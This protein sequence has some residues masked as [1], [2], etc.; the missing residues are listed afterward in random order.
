LRARVPV[1]ECRFPPPSGP[2]RALTL[3]S[4]M[5]LSSRRVAACLA[6]LLVAAAVPYCLYLYRSWQSGNELADVLAE[7]DRTAAPWRLADLQSRQSPIGD[8]LTAAALIKKARL[9][10]P[11][12]FS[13]V[14][15]EFNILPN[16]P[17]T[18]EQY[19]KLRAYLDNVDENVKEAR[20][21]IEL[22]PG[23][24]PVRVSADFFGS[25]VPHLDDL[26]R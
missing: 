10:T 13:P 1:V 26:R 22:P 3:R 24:F 5:R 2:G 19:V 7:L 25:L 11:R 15:D 20:Q 6:V 18:P 9:P 14:L 16:R 12:K 17:L 4:V 8:E 23:R 21:L